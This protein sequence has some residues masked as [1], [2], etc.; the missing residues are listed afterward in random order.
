M[1]KYERKYIVVNSSTVIK[2]FEKYG[3]DMVKINIE[4]FKGKDALFRNSGCYIK[5]PDSG[6]YVL[7]KMQ[8]SNVQH[9]KNIKEP[10]DRC[11]ETDI[12]TVLR[13]YDEDENK[14]VNFSKENKDVLALK[15]Y[16]DAYS[17]QIEEMINKGLLWENKDKKIKKH[18]DG[19]T[20]ASKNVRSFILTED[21]NGQPFENPIAYISFENHNKL[22]KLPQYPLM[23]SEGVSVKYMGSGN[24]DVMVFKPNV[25]LIQI[26]KASSK[27]N[28]KPKYTN[29]ETGEK[30]EYTNINIQ[31]LITYD[32]ILTGTVKFQI[33]ASKG[34]IKLSAFWA[35][36]LYV[37]RNNKKQNSQ[38][39]DLSIVHAM[40]NSSLTKTIDDSDDDE[41]DEEE[42]FEDFEE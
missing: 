39:V 25:N 12:N 31:N 40:Q 26:Y 9:K 32:S 4:D 22:N 15:L 27:I 6:E 5:H 21:G 3:N 14:Q 35:G 28:T 41:N 20:V 23:N 38:N 19:I 34:S 30:E 10:E 17:F 11:Y 8:L 7:F 18:P 36:N 2:S 1:S 16:A 29:P 13:V 42:K 24:P 33:V 37:M